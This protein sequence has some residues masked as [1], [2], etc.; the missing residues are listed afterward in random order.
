M[1]KIGLIGAAGLGRSTLAKEIAREKNITFLPSKNITRPI[2]KKH[3]WNALSA[4]R[5]GCNV[6]KFLAR[7]DIEFELVSDRIYQES[8]LVCGFVTDRTTLECF[9]YSLLRI[10][11]YS[12]ND[13]KTLEDICRGNMSKYT[14]IFYFPYT[15]G[16]YEDNGIRTMS[17]YFQWKIDMMIRGLL[18]D[19]DINYVQMPGKMDMQEKS[20]F[21]LNCLHHIPPTSNM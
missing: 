21:V 19:W 15:S 7:K 10:E 13:L 12:D 4:S 11:D 20:Q 1:E 9:A 5:S 18:N 17:S 14:H 16:W 8:L 2:L 3:G 6:E